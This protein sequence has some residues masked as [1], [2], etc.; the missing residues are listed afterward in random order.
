M[1]LS[2]TGYGKATSKIGGNSVTVEIKSLNG[3]SFE[4]GLRIP[5]TCRE[6]ELE[7]R[8]LL[9]QE[10][11]RG[12]AEASIL[13]DNGN[14]SK[15]G[16]LNKKFIRSF[17][18]ELKLLERELKL[19]HSDYL[20]TVLA[21]PNAMGSEKQEIN[22]TEW[23]Q[24]EQLIKKAVKAFQS[25][26]FI[27]GKSLEKDILLRIKSINRCLSEI[28]K[29]ETPRLAA[30]K[31]RLNKMLSGIDDASI[32]KNRFEQELIYYLEKIDI[33]EEK[34]RLKTHCDY[35]LGTMNEK[36]A[37]GKKLGFIIQEIGREINTIGS[38]ANDAGIQRFVVEMKDELEK[39]KE[40]VANVL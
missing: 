22:E 36:E 29:F 8:N 38:K 30:I 7:I 12:R 20:N 4:L 17:V 27:E 33:T 24:I 2:M 34:V 35:F 25:F 32:D 14:D 19:P 3:K 6:K 37:N 18:H 15:K 1:I 40:Q 26:R 16:S 21:L 11:Q 9:S 39:M 13:I 5:L 28:E 23:K 31:A 10:I